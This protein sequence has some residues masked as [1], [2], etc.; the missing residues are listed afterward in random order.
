MRHSVN[1]WMY[2]AM[3]SVQ[4][5][6]NSTVRWVFLDFGGATALHSPFFM[7]QLLHGPNGPEMTEIIMPHQATT[8]DM[9]ARGCLFLLCG[10]GG[11]RL[12]RSVTNGGRGDTGDR[13]GG[14][15]PRPSTCLPTAV[16]HPSA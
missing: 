6:Y 4:L 16:Q 9:R 8:V 10:G 7:A 3:P 2:C 14:I 1:G 15:G 11:G 5:A 12:A 13:V